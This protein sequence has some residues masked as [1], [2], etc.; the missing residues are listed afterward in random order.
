MTTFTASGGGLRVVNAQDIV[1]LGL[2]VVDSV[3]KFSI[4]RWADRES[5]P[6]HSLDGGEHG[7]VD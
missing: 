2:E 4:E 5:L 1:D 3:A 6:W 7:V